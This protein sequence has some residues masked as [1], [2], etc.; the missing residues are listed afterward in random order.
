LFRAALAELL[1]RDLGFGVVHEVA[2]LDEAIERL[3]QDDTVSF[4]CFDLKMPGMNDAASLSAIR[5]VFPDLCMII[6]SASERREDILQALA[7]G[8]HGYI[9]KALKINEIKTA[10]QTILAGGIFVPPVLAKN[11]PSTQTPENRPLNVALSPR[12]T[13]VLQLMAAGYSNKEIARKIGLS[14]GTVKVHVSALYRALNAHNRVTAVAA[15]SRL[16]VP[17]K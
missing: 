4:A 10:L 7:S 14:E 16:A 12:Q 9:P 17:Q 5:D 13:D 15:M 8:I 2:S 3:D 6:V 11:G 1:K